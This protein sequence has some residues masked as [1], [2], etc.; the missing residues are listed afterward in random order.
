MHMAILHEE[1]KLLIKQR[2]VVFVLLVGDGYNPHLTFH[3]E[4]HTESPY[5]IKSFLQMVDGLKNLFTMDEAVVGEGST[6]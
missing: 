5:H 4:I 1:S 2:L 6:G 3:T